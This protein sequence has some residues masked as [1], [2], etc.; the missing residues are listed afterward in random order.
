LNCGTLAVN[1]TAEIFRH[2]FELVGLLLGLA[3]YNGV[4]LDV[5]LPLVLYK[6]LLG[7]GMHGTDQPCV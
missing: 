2:E 3:I 4:I 1:T 6:K 7:F 5:K